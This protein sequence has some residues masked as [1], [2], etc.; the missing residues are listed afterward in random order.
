L[1]QLWFEGTVISGEKWCAVFGRSAE[2]RLQLLPVCVAF[3]A[4]IVGQAVQ[5]NESYSGWFF[6]AVLEGSA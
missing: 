3:N 1:V 5:G 2:R 4:C 6:R